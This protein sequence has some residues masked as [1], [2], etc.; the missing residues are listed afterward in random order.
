LYKSEAAEEQDESD[1]DA[2]REVEIGGPEIVGRGGV[3]EVV[4]AV[5][6]RGSMPIAGDMAAKSVIRTNL[7]GIGLIESLRD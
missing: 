3:G 1:P 4:S 2:G 6:C 5:V 7:E